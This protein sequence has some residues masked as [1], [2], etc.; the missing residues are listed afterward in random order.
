MEKLTTEQQLA[1]SRMQV[2]SLRLKSQIQALTD[3]L[4]AN[5]NAFKNL[6]QSF[7]RTL[8]IDAATHEFSVTELEFKQRPATA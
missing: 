3:Q 1:L 7:A 6:V 4:N 2:T 8:N 5:E